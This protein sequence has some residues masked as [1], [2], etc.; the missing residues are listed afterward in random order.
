[1]IFFL[2]LDDDACMDA[3][4]HGCMGEICFIQKD[5]LLMYACLGMMYGFFFCIFLKTNSN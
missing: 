1:M 5:E 4:M 2:N 3:W